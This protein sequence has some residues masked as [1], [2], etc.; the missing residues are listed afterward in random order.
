MRFIRQLLATMVLTSAAWGQPALT[1]IQDILYTADG[2]RFTGTVFISWNSFLGGDGSHIASSTIT[3]AIV[4]GV[5]RVQLVPT[6]NGSAGAQ[7]AV[8]YN[9]RGRTQFTEIWAVPPNDLTMRVR[10]IRVSTGTVVGPQPV[11]SPVQIGDV[12]GLSNELAVRPMRG[13]GYAIGRVAII[14]QAGQVDGAAGNLADCMRVDGSS[15]PCGGGS[16]GIL[17]QFADSEIPVGVI[18]GSNTSFLLSFAPVPAASLELYRNGLLMKPGVDY[19]IS[20]RTVTFF[21]ASTP[22]AGDLLQANYRYADPDNPVGSLTSA[23]VVCSAPGAATSSTTM[24]PLGSCTIPAGLLVFGD[25]I[26]VRFQYAHVGT[27]AGFTGEVRFGSATLASR[28]GASSETAL[29]GR[30]ELGVY[31]G[32]QSWNLESWGNGLSLATGVG[33]TSENISQALTVSL[34]AQMATSTS[35]S[36]VLRNFTVVR[37]PSQVNP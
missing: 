27:S 5:L 26:E 10:D 4:N 29:V 19:G 32:G 31:S 28:A 3:T 21:V 35:D 18:D 17:P 7:Y 6:T 2:Q 13:I 23:Q 24:T 8:T 25:R 1:K 16:G 9:S 12:V 30:L 15:G 14:N 22:Q 36:V 20:L 34:R 37:Y 11:T 33:V